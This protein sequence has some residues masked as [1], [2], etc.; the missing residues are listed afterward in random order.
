MQGGDEAAHVVA[1]ADVKGL[2]AVLETR[3]EKLPVLA[4]VVVDYMGR[5]VVAQGIVPG[6]H[7]DN[8]C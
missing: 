3:V 8:S 7:Q 4:T 1:G 2:A 5:R 6:M